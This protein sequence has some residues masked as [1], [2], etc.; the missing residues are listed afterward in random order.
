MAELALEQ[1]NSRSLQNDRLQSL[2]AQAAA[3]AKDKL[4]KEVIKKSKQAILRTIN[5]AFAATLVGII[6]AYLIMSVQLFAGNLMGNE[7]IKLESWEVMIWAFLTILLILVM[8]IFFTLIAFL[9]DPWQVTLAG[10]EVISNWL[11]GK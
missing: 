3:Q 7:L 11:F 1:Q 2:K 5:A 4:K 8:L 10:W 6:V 9:S